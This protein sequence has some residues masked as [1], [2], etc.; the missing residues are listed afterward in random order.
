[1]QVIRQAIKKESRP[2]D[3]AFGIDNIIITR[4]SCQYFPRG[5]NSKSEAQMIISYLRLE[6]RTDI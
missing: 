5:S 1:M 3:T 4:E 2:T 6:I